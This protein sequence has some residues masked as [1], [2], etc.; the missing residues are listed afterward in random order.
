MT[1]TEATTTLTELQDSFS[2]PELNE[3]SV[4][5]DLLGSATEQVE[6]LLSTNSAL[7]ATLVVLGVL[8][9]II[10]CCLGACFKVKRLVILQLI[11]IG[12]IG[13]LMLLNLIEL[14]SFKK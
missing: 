1:E 12:K 14:G 5:S 6:V 3:D 4:V 11:Y 13:Y 10:F 7:I 8:L 9:L 2:E